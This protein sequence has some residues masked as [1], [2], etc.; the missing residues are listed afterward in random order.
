MTGRKSGVTSIGD[1]RHTSSTVPH[2]QSGDLSSVDGSTAFDSVSRD[3]GD[4]RKPSSTRPQSG[5]VSSYDDSTAFDSVSRDKNHFEDNRSQ[6]TDDTSKFLRDSESSLFSK[7]LS[8]STPGFKRESS[9]KCFTGGDSSFSVTAPLAP[10]MRKSND[11]SELTINKLRFSDLGVYGRQKEVD[12]LSKVYDDCIDPEASA[13]L[14]RQ[15]VLIGGASGTGKSRLANVLRSRTDGIKS[16]FVRGKF[17]NAQSSQRPFAGIVDA[18]AELCGALVQLR[19]DDEKKSANLIL[20]IER[21][22]GSELSLLLDF[23]PELSEVLDVSTSMRLTRV[24]SIMHEDGA[25]SK[26]QFNFAFKRLMRVVCRCFQPFILFIDDLQWA[27]APSLEILEA[28]M[29]DEANS[30]LIVI[31]AYRS[32]EVDETHVLYRIIEDLDKS[33]SSGIFTMLSMKLGN[34]NPDA[35]HEVVQCLLDEDADTKTRELAEICY[36]KTQGNA[37]FLLRFMQMLVEAQ[38]VTFSLGTLTWHWDRRNIEAKT[39]STDNVLDIITER[40]EKLDKDLTLMLRIAAHLGSSFDDESLRLVWDHFDER[41][42]TDDEKSDF[43]HALNSL[44]KKGFILRI[45][46]VANGYCWEHDKIQEAALATVSEENEKNFTR[47]MGEILAA[48]LSEVELV[49]S[50]RIFVVVDL[51]NRSL[52][53]QEDGQKRLHLALL[54]LRAC[55]QAMSFSAF[56]T[57]TDYASNGILL[58]PEDPWRRKHQILTLSLYCL[59]AKAHQCTGN[60]EEMKRLCKIVL[61]RKD[62][63]VEDKFSAYLTWVNSCM[64]GDCP[65][66]EGVDL[67]LG[68]LE[69]LSVKFPKNK[70]IT[71]VE[72]GRQLFITR[73]RAKSL[74]VSTMP[75]LTDRRAEMAMLLLDKL[76]TCFYATLDPRLPLCML[77]SFD[78]T[79]KHGYADISPSVLAWAACFITGALKDRKGAEKCADDAIAL[80]DRTTVRDESRTLFVSH[81]FTYQWVRPLN[82]STKPLLQAYDQG[83]RSG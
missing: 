9:R 27:D 71:L 76:V 77:K 55:Q 4:T 49:R 39:T 82:A 33:S 3:K 54:N 7:A 35:V 19:R 68:L 47:K 79:L 31:G 14:D 30:N 45:P 43:E 2:S 69:S 57:A 58:L 25:K 23:I 22:L 28:L 65:F 17:D 13:S 63:K 16:I 29:A 42:H 66:E 51:L 21:E 75:K 72:I 67:I 24:A 12:N 15:L 18:C 70:V 56:T 62:I 38:L 1:I 52:Y 48:E 41:I 20:T 83:I 34:L 8:T 59:G 11:I 78:L 37:F 50:A 46:G 53:E 64:T 44:I 60:S 36:D 40:M 74:D 32:N 81:C 73:K 80:L 6:S 26:N 61:D 10:S 5:D